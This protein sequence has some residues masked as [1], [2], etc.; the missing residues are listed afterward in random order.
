MHAADTVPIVCTTVIHSKFNGNFQPK[1]EKWRGIDISS[2]A[3]QPLVWF[4][5]GTYKSL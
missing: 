4:Y 3:I 5:G 1:Y 2:D